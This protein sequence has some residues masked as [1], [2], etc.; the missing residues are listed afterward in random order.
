MKKIVLA[1]MVVGF[2]LL[3]MSNGAQADI[4]YIG[5]FTQDNDVLRVDFTVDTE[6]SVTFFTSSWDDGGFDPVLTLWD[7]AGNYIDDWDDAGPNINQS[8]VSSNGVSY[9]FGWNDI[10]AVSTL[11]AGSYSVTITQWDNYAQ[12]TN[13]A[14][15]FYYDLE[16]HFTFVMGLG[17]QPDFNGSL[18]TWFDDPETP[19][20]D[21][22]GIEDPRTGA[23]EF[24]VVNVDA[25]PVPVPAS[26]LLFGSA[27]AGLIGVKRRK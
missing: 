26:L 18:S 2:S 22:T 12:G 21:P 16:P 15:G 3:G 4:D 17:T 5:A 11:A 8:P 7:S 10:Y 1:G 20:Y 13:L 9:S 27:L 25:A 6:K 24:H 23:L 19:E 14:D